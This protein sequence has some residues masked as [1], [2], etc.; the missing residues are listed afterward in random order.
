MSHYETLGVPK[1]ATPEDIKAARR[2]KA[3]EAHPDRPGG[4]DRA[5]QKVNDAYVVLS[6]PETRKIY[7]ETGS[8]GHGQSP[9]EVAT[10]TLVQ[11]FAQSFSAG[12]VNIVNKAREAI[13]TAYRRLSEAEAA[14]RQQ[15]HQLEVRRAKIRTKND[16][17]NI[18]HQVIDEQ[19]AKHRKVLH[20]IEFTR[21]VNAVIDVMLDDYED[22][23]QPPMPAYHANGGTTVYFGS[24]V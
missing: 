23:E 6:D 22:D 3:S 24:T 20:E 13:A 10:Q 15:L 4:S 9:A 14:S 21:K 8:D 19:M 12:Q 17:L 16:R 1:D 2:R 7:D 5:M 18:A 11:L